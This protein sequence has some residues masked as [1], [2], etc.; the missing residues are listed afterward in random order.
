M[1]TIKLTHEQISILQNALGLAEAKYTELHEAITK[2]TL[3]RGNDA[4]IEQL[5]IGQYYH[6]KSCEFAN[7]NQSLING[8]LDK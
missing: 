2:A 5:K 6:V 3:V 4:N 8:D 1:R 7:L